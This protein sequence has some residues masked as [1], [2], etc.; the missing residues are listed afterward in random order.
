[1]SQAQPS[2]ERQRTASGNRQRIYVTKD[3][4][5]RSGEGY[6]FRPTTTVHDVALIPNYFSSGEEMED[7]YSEQQRQP[8][9]D[10]QRQ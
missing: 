9:Q 2:Q 7:H 8:L 6:E 4:F 3:S 5:V 10:T 1:V